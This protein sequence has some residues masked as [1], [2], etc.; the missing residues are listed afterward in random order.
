MVNRPCLDCGALSPNTRCRPCQIRHGNERYAKRGTS[1]ERGYGS[2]YRQRRAGVLADATHCDTCGE[3]FTPDNPATGGHVV[4]LRTMP[5]H[6]RKA[7]ATTA[8][9]TP[10]CQRCNYGW[11]RQDPPG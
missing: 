8:P 4:D 7:S 11:R 2:A 10:Q 5:R 9:L 6:E 3:P 1:T